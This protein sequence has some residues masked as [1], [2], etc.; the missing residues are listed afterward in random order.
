MEEKGTAIEGGK[1]VGVRGRKW[2][3]EGCGVSE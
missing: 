2:S 1:E 3:E